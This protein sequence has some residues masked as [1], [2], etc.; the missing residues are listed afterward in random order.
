M[1][2]F[3]L[4]LCV[5]SSRCSQSCL[6]KRCNSNFESSQVPRN[7]LNTVQVLRNHIKFEIVTDRAASGLLK[8]TSVDSDFLPGVGR[9][10]CKYKGGEAS[11]MIGQGEKEVGGD[12]KDE[13][14]LNSCLA[15]VGF[16]TWGRRSLAFF[17]TTTAIR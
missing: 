7:G 1:T 8:S 12:G 4:Y 15:E 16:S 17:M 11:Q 10:L 3:N 5:T 6:G 9:T 2:S 13:Q 14:S